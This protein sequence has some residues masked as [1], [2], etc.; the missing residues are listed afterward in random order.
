MG[1]YER[2]SLLNGSLR[3]DSAPGQGTRLTVTLPWPVND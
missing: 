1:M 3:I 2:A